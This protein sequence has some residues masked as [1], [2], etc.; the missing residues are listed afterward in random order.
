MGG[1]IAIVGAPS[2]GCADD[3]GSWR[4][5]L[6]LPRWRG[7]AAGTIGARTG[8]HIGAGRI[9]GSGAGFGSAP[10]PAAGRPATACVG[11]RR[12][13]P[14]RVPRA[15]GP[16]QSAAE[17]PAID[18]HRLDQRIDRPAGG[19]FQ[20]VHR[21]AHDARPERSPDVEE[22]VGLGSVVRA[23]LHHLAGQHVEDA[24]PPRRIERDRDVA[25]SHP[26]VDLRPFRHLD[27]GSDDL[28]SVECEVRDSG[29]GV[30]S[31]DPHPDDR[32]RIEATRVASKVEAIGNLL[33]GPLAT[34]RPSL[35][36]TRSDARR[37]TSSISWL[38]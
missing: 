31:R 18:R 4:N 30:V 23:D 13:R 19:E 10:G 15:K 29:R 27:A 1:C 35:M 24:G 32:P 22:D 25:R 9:S 3:N 36:S 33:D 16:L 20:L 12:A 6:R 28:A 7:V 2:R 8:I 5:G 34:T 38:T 21:A 14:R 26:E 37:T 11:Y 17:A